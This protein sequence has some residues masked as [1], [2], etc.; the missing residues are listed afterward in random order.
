MYAIDG[1]PPSTLESFELQ[2][3][4]PSAAL[5][6]SHAAACVPPLFALSLS[7]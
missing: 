1:T 4:S 5:A 6:Q 3:K 2:P 7:P